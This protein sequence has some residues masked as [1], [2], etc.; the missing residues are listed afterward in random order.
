MGLR[1]I[2]ILLR[3]KQWYKNLLVFL[4][5]LFSGKLFSLDLIFITTLGFL[6]FCFVSSINYIINDFVDIKKDRAHIEKKKRPL[7]S[8]S[9]SK[10]SAMFILAFMVLIS[11]IISLFLPFMFNMLL[12]LFFFMTLMYTLF[13]KNILFV[14]MLFIGMNFVLRAV[15]GAFVVT[16][17]LM[18]YVVVS[19]WLIV[20]PFFLAL[21][22][23]VSKREADYKLLGKDA[24]DHKV[25]LE[26]YTPELTGAFMIM[27]TAILVVVYA[28]YSVFSHNFALLITFPFALFCLFRW[29]YLVKSGSI[30]SRHPE[31][32]YKDSQ[33]VI[34][35]IFWLSSLVI[36]LY[37]L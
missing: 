22:L 27:F 25:V 6:A 26:K 13:F 18:P 14:D 31:L 12:L 36:G 33:L 17:G 24:K 20:A 19:P 7:A 8:G 35:F 11:I 32:I 23:V 9:I 5:L 28:I 34:G 2:I 3:I 4:P 30:I 1:D 16:I 37:V 10:L 29:F 15:S 21:L